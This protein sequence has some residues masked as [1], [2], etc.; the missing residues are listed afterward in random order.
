PERGD[1]RQPHHARANDLRDDARQAPAAAGEQQRAGGGE[2]E[3][4]QRDRLSVHPLSSLRSSMSSRSRTRKMS[5]RIA[6]PTTASAAATVMVLSANSWPSRFSSLRENATGS[7]LTPLAISSI[8]VRMISG[9]WRT[10]PTIGPSGNRAARRSRNQDG[11]S[12]EA[13]M[14]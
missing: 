7:R 2:D 10:S 9:V 1:E 14:S 12:R 4:R 5:T 13:P 6:S 3:D 11:S 8:E